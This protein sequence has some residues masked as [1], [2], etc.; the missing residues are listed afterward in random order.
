MDDPGAFFADIFRLAQQDW[1][2]DLARAAAEDPA[3]W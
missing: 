3:S 2:A 1:R